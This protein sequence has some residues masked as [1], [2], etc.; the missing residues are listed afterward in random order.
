MGQ[1]ELE[2]KICIYGTVKKGEK[3]IPGA[4]TKLNSNVEM[5]LEHN[6]RARLQ[7][8]RTNKIFGGV[9]HGA[10]KSRDAILLDFKKKVE[11]ERLRGTQLQFY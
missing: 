1:N 6:I 2:L 3:I 4:A 7:D 10:A 8:E 9:K 5:F 11:L